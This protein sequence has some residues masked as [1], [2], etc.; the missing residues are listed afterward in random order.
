VWSKND[1]RSLFYGSPFSPLHRHD[2]SW[3]ARDGQLAGSKMPSHG[4]W[5][6]FPTQ[7]YN[8][9]HRIAGFQIKKTPTVIARCLQGSSEMKAR[10]PL[11]RCAITIESYGC[12]S[13][14]QTLQDRSTY[15]VKLSRKSLTMLVAPVRTSCAFTAHYLSIIATKILQAS[16]GTGR[17]L[18]KACTIPARRH[19]PNPTLRFTKNV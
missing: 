15:I 11:H 7:S 18:H 9:W 6:Y 10:A 4:N 2:F 12:N 3:E 5:N 14:V 1:P 8:C 19:L 13:M 16:S 17:C